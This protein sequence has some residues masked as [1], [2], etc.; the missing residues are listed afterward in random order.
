[1]HRV[2]SLTTYIVKG[3]PFR[4]SRLHNHWGERVDA[5]GLAYLPH[6]VVTT[7]WLKLTGRRPEMPWLGYRAV[8]RLDGLIEPDWRI[9]EFGSGMS[10]IWFARRCA[11]VLSLETDD[12]WFANV[13]AQL[14]R[15]GLE[16]VDCRLCH[17]TADGVPD[18]SGAVSDRQGTAFDLALVDGARRDL[19]ME[20]ALTLV[21][22]GGYVFLDNTD[23]PNDDCR[24][25]AARL[26]D[27]AARM[28]LFNDLSPGIVMVN[29]GTLAQ[30]AEPP[31]SRP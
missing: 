28:W 16:N 4:R 12:R 7:I 6:S 14:G 29:E 19:A 30:L 20:V 3:T 17:A 5:K 1:M 9:V 2:Q 27:A 24:I 31:T 15:A 11:F 25:A 13:H 21:K 18:Y 23:L 8:K 10:T 22:P 26:S